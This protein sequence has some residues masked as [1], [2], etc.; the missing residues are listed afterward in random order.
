M[1][2]YISKYKLVLHAFL[3]QTL[4]HFVVHTRNEGGHNTRNQVEPIPVDLHDS[5]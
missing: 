2:K 1:F 3:L 5:R 4:L